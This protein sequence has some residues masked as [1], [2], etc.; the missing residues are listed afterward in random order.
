MYLLDLENLGEPLLIDSASGNANGF[1][2]AWSPAGHELL[3]QRWLQNGVDNTSSGPLLLLGDDGLSRSLR[4]GAIEQGTRWLDAGRV[5]VALQTG[6]EVIGT[7]GR[8][9]ASHEGT[10]TGAGMGSARRVWSLRRTGAGWVLSSGPPKVIWKS[11]CLT[12][13]R[14]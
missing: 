6:F 13:Q 7:D 2:F 8:L 10:V 4:E 11:T 3:Y 9:V 12:W 5:L 14:R 1:Q